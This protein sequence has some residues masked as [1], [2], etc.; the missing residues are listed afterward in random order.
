MFLYHDIMIK[1]FPAGAGDCILVDFIKEDYRILIDGGY[2]ETYHKY[3]NKYLT[4]LAAQGKRINLL[5]VMHID[6]DHIGGIQAFFEENGS[7]E[8]PSV[9]GVD[10][11]WYNAFFHVNTME[12]HQKAIPYAIREVLRGSLAIHNEVKSN[13]RNDISVIQGNTVAGLLK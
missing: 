11:V 2:A 4:E 6:S 12:V 8:K 10:E 9:I 1:V 13:G 7:A 3:L 5:I